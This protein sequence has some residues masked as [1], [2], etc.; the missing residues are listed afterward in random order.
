MIRWGVS[1]DRF[2]PASPEQRRAARQ[3]LGIGD[4]AL[5]V[6]WAGFLQQTDEP[7]LH[8]SLKVAQLARAALGEGVSS[9]FC[10]KPEHYREEHA[11]L[12]AP[13]ISVLRTAEDYHAART[14]ADLFLSP[15]TDTRSTAAPPLAWIEA[16][17]MGVP[18]LTTPLPGAEE[19]AVSGR[20]GL[21]SATPEE[22]AQHVV[23]M[24]G[25]SALLDRLRRGA[26]QVAQER[27]SMERA[28]AEYASLWSSLAS[29][30]T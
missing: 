3:R 26:R 22:A 24:A 11:C 13:G 20:S 19:A 9:L 21:I 10:F 29:T 27:F 6:V 1:T 5:V 18:L 28:V 14:A 4:S 30:R 12:N 17:A 8:F 15:I 2:V 25:D 23:S 16:L 7:D